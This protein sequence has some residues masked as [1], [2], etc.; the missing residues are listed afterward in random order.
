MYNSFVTTKVRPIRKLFIIEDDHEVFLSIFMS[1][2]QDIDGILNLILKNDK[3]LFSEINKALVDSY[4]PDIVLNYSS[5]EDKMISEFFNAITY[6]SKST[7]YDLHNFCS[8]I[9]TFSSTPYLATKDPTLIPSKVYATSS[10]EFTANSLF[11]ALNFGVMDKRN[12]VRLKRMP[13]IFQDVTISCIDDPNKIKSNIFEN[14]TKYHNLTNN[15]GSAYTSSSIY[16]KNYNNKRFFA[17]KHKN[18]LFISHSSD[19]NFILYF[20]N[21]RN[22]YNHAKLAWLPLEEIEKYREII[23]YETILVVSNE[24][25]IN[26]L[27]PDFSNNEYI[28]ADRYYFPSNKERWINFEHN[29]YLTDPSDIK[30]L[31]HPNEKTFADI[32]FG[33][34]FIFEVRGPAE[35]AYPKKYF[36]EDC[37]SNNFVDKSIFPYHF[38]RLSNK[39]LSKYFKHF[40]PY[41]TSGITET[42][43]L[44][45]FVN[46]LHSHFHHCKLTL[47]QTAKTFILE[48]LIQLLGGVNNA[49][50]ISDK[51][52]FDL[53]V[54]LTPHTRTERLVQKAFPNLEDN[55]SQDELISYIGTLKERGDI[56]LSSTIISLEIIEN[57]LKEKNTSPTLYQGKLQNLY[58]ANILLRGKYFRCEHCS[59]MLWFPLETLQR[60]NHCVECGNVVHMPLFD[61]GKALNDH[62]KLNQ[63][64]ARAVDQGQLAT[65]LLINYINKQGYNHFSY[66]SNY[67][68]F[69]E[70]KLISDIDVLV[71]IDHKLGLCECKSNATFSTKQIDELLNIGA[72]VNCDFIMLSCL[73]SKEDE[74]I[75]KTIEYLDSKKLDIPVF[76]VTGSELFAEKPVRIYEYFKINFKINDF[77]KGP[78]LL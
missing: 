8:P 29:Q 22:S 65:L 26:K 76:I 11:L 43:K 58:N 53:L 77:D 14:K 36:L 59:A 61:N 69:K 50:L 6:N 75:I 37:F 74:R 39:G 71:K 34:G 19:F 9:F 66:E 21:T 63:L 72:L 30:T 38:I 24:K 3:L 60:I 18:Y 12:Y 4:D 7:N 49:K 45:S 28:I 41:S 35:L 70:N 32:G 62:F 33:G 15:I 44:P 20:W 27:P 10:V 48:Q 46:L 40:A 52:I 16:D 1:L 13:S 5:L 17:D 47:Q 57:K 31:T 54:S 56:S 25:E 23:S 55:V 67:E 68:I 78:I 73:L 51:K 42:F 2:M 64:V